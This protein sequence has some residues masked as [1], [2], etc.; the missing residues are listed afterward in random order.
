MTLSPSPY[1]YQ[2]LSLYLSLRSSVFVSGTVSV[3]VPVG[4]CSFSVTVCEKTCIS[5]VSGSTIREL[6]SRQPP[7]FC[8]YRVVEEW[9]INGKKKEGPTE[10]PGE[11]DISTEGAI[12][13]TS[14]TYTTTVFRTLDVGQLVLY[15]LNLVFV[16]TG[17]SMFNS[18]FIKITY[19]NEE[20]R[21][22]RASNL[23]P[24]SFRLVY[25]PGKNVN[26]Q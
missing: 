18:M 5:F 6:V 3:R 13:E 23:N 7:I 4:Y 9:C 22:I 8:F 16:G 2:Y 14:S 11:L 15:G 10:S 24:H 25:T 19:V 1:Q 17:R 20:K 21:I 12:S 26:I